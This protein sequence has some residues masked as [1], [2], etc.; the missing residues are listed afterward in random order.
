VET[1]AEL[2]SEWAV[3]N[4]VWLWLLIIVAWSAGFG[5]SFPLLD[6]R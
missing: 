5:Y 1:E 2:S 6:V 3:V 4:Y